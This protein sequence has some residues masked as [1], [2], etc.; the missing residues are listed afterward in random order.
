MLRRDLLFF[1]GII[2]WGFLSYHVIPWPT[3]TF[4]ATYWHLV[5]LLLG[6]LGYFI[7]IIVFSYVFPKF[8]KWGDKRLF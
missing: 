8:G 3:T 7:L 2:V 4:D 6:L 1:V 5:W